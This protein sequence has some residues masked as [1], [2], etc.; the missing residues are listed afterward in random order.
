MHKKLFLHI[1]KRILNEKYPDVNFDFYLS[2]CARN[3][4]MGLNCNILKL[5]DHDQI[6]SG[7]KEIWL[8]REDMNFKFVVMHLYTQLRGSLTILFL[9]KTLTFEKMSIEYKRYSSNAHVPKT[10]YPGSVG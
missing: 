10:A 9:E 2:T 4:H 5:H 8:K 3:V 1:L 7:I 6:I